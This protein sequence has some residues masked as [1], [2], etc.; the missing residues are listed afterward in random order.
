MSKKKGVN[1]VVMNELE[2]DLPCI[3]NFKNMY[4]NC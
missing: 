3:Q 1:T 2:N 4:I